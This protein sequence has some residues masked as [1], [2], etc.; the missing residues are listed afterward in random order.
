MMKEKPMKIMK[1]NMMKIKKIREND[2]RKW[3]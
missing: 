3:E 2:E 1:E